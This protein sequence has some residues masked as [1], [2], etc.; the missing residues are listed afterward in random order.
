MSNLPET[1]FFFI[2]RKRYITY[3]FNFIYMLEIFKYFY[4]LKSHYANTQSYANKNSFVLTK[5]IMVR[6]FLSTNNIATNKKLR[7]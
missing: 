5:P 4:T 1:D 2:L 6:F 7:L 3:H